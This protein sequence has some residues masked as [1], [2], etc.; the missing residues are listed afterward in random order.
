MYTEDTQ[1]RM[2]SSTKPGSSC[3]VA[4][5]MAKQTTPY[6]GFEGPD[7]NGSE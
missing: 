6:E 3:R 1:G 4:Q 2:A 7:M 5:L